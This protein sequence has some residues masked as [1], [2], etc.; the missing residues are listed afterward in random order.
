MKK[1]KI[2]GLVG[3]S[4][5]SLGLFAGCGNAKDEN[6]SVDDT[7]TIRMSWWGN[8]DRHKATLE[9]IRAFEEKHPTIK[10]KAEYSGWDGMVEKM[11]TQ[12]A[13]GTE[14]DLM[15]INYDWYQTFSPNG[16]G[17]YDL[18]ELNNII[19]FSGYSQ[20]ALSTATIENKLNGIPHGENSFV[21]GLNKTT[22]EKFGVELPETWEDYIKAAEAFDEGYYPIATGGFNMIITYLSQKTGESFLDEEGNINYT[23]ADLIEGINWYQDLIDNQVLPTKKEQIET[24]GTAHAS[25]IKEFIE[26]NY[27]GITEW[28][29]GLASYAQ[30]LE[31]ADQELVIPTYPEIED[32][33]TTGVIK[34][35]TMLFSVSKNTKYPEEAAKL[36]DFLLN[37]PEGV[38]LMGTARGIPVNTKAVEILEE[39]G[40]INGIAL[41][42]KEY[43]QNTE[44]TVSSPYLGMASIMEAYNSPLESFELGQID[45]QT[46][47]REII[48]QV[49]SVISDIK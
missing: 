23:E 36:L 42:A 41:A 39:D 40:Q 1:K 34:K 12:I 16:E 2:V 14:A 48:E 13:G 21:I 20:E 5:V 49:E 7:V 25:T 33:V 28:T 31:E 27:A 46:A 37:D 44:G 35:P 19:D 47:A 9:A 11:T 43:Q 29:G 24:M 45:A 6:E 15:Q 8:D 4:V 22:F 18:N 30:V 10:V 32:A 3:I 38:R 26:G 17:F